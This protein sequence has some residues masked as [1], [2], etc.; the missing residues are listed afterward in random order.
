MKYRELHFLPSSSQA[1]GWVL[2]VLHDTKVGDFWPKQPR[3]S[4]LWDLDIPEFSLRDWKRYHDSTVH[5]ITATI[6]FLGLSR[7]STIRGFTNV[8]I[9]NSR[10][11]RA[12]CP[13]R[14][15]F[16]SPTKS[17]PKLPPL[18]HPIRSCQ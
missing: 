2:D 17:A 11:M 5:L 7:N 12:P 15:Q 14:P 1:A 16:T 9:A 10:V 4:R 13:G 18:F 6:A 3:S 8:H